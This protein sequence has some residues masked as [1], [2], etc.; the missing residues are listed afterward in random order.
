MNIKKVKNLKIQYR[1]KGTEHNDQELDETLRKVMLTLGFQF[2]DQSFFTN[3][4]TRELNFKPLG[5]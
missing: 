3:I 5:E 2:Q 1:L 4:K